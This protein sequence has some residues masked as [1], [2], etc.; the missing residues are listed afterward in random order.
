MS[1]N[2]LFLFKSVTHLVAKPAVTKSMVG[3]F[4]FS[5]TVGVQTYLNK[6]EQ[7]ERARSIHDEG[8]KFKKK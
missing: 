6:L 1:S 7:A 8:S 3:T 5:F 2:R 4:S